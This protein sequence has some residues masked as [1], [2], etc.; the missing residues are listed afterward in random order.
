MENVNNNGFVA[1]DSTTTMQM[2]LYT[3]DTGTE[4]TENHTPTGN[5]RTTT[6][7]KESEQ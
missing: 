7:L 3:Q 1:A 2:D 4:M 5:E 6:E